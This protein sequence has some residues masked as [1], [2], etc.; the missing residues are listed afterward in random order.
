MFVVIM[1]SVFSANETSWGNLVLKFAWLKILIWEF[2]IKV[3]YT[4]RLRRLI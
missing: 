1:R 3:K 2:G 4:P